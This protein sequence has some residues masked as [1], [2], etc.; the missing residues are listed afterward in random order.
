MSK[1]DYDVIPL[2]RFVRDSGNSAYRDQTLCER[3]GNHNFGRAF[4]LKL[5]ERQR[6][7]GE[8]TGWIDLTSAGERFLVQHASV[9]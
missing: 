9:R 7:Q 1:P 3:F 4:D 6:W 5:I 8:D 2:L